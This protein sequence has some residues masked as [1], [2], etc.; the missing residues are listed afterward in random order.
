MK[1]LSLILCPMILVL[2]V[3]CNT[4]PPADF[5]LAQVPSVDKKD[6]ELV[7]ITVG[8]VPKSRNNTIE[9]NHLVPPAW[10]EALLDAINRSLLFS[11]DKERK[12]SISVKIDEFNAPAAGFAMTSTCGASYEVMDRSNG[13]VL[14]YERIASSGTVPMDFA[15]AGVVRALESVNRCGRNNIYRFLNKLDGSDL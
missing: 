5:T 7:S 12:V 10:K 9:T 3:G 14:F 11:D 8:Y 15:F 4:V 2:L 13:E 6:V 1:K